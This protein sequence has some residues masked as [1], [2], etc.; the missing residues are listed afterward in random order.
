M[1]LRSMLI[2]MTICAV[3]SDAVLIPFYPQFF[4]ARYGM[5]SPVHAGAYVAFIS[6]IV[7]LTLPAWA[8]IAKRF[9]AMHLLVYTQ[10]AAG[11]LSIASYWAPT[12]PLFWVL[13]LAMFMCKSSYLLTYPYLMRLEPAE[14][15]AHTI[16][17]LSV[18][19]H[20]GAIAGAAA[21]GLVMQVWDAQ[22]CIFAMAAGDFA[23]M[24]ICI[25][26]IRSHAI[27]RRCRFADEATARTSARPRLRAR[28]PILRLALVMLTFDFCVYLIRPF[29]SSYWQR[30]SGSTSEFVSG[31]VFAIPG[32]AALLALRINKHCADKGRRLPDWITPNLLLCTAGIL[33]QGIEAPV[34]IIVG[35]VLFGWALFQ[36]IV[37]LDVT[38]FALS[39]PT[40]YAADYS[41]IN[42]FQNLGVLLASFAAGMIVDET[43]LRTP[44]FIASAGM[45]LCVPMGIWL[46][47][48]KASGDTKHSALPANTLP[49]DAVS[50]N[51]LANPGVS[52][53]AN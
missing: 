43:S 35:R 31:L 12:L 36:I 38:M 6:I 10:C 13:S 1:K 28:L 18:V 33:L 47:D 9:D 7:M 52:G 21:G 51:N 5:T 32:M 27:A 20:F 25:C 44:F 2:L 37:Q 16:G 17:L 3:I 26:L 14:S 39:T 40:S 22:T 19:V 11:V 53:H 30:A 45:L 41:V 48:R 4:A 42:F 15:H 46:L 8:R 49:A 23:Q 24:V 50:R 34:W 29:M